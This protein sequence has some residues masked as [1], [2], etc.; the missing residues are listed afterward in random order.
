M[1][2]VAVITGTRADYGILYPVLK[3]I[4]SSQNLKLQ[5]IVC[6]MHL[7]PDFGMTIK[8]IE[9]DGFEISDKFE[10]V[11]SSDTGSSMAKTVGLSIMYAA[12]SFERLK[13]DIVLVLGDRGEMLAAAIAAC[14][15]NIPVAHIHGGEVSGTVDESIRHA[16]TKLSHIHFPA[17][18][19]SRNRIIKMGEK[20]ENVFVVG[21]PGLDVIKSTKYIS[22]EEFLNK[23]GLKDDKIIL[24]TQHPV[25]TE[26]DDVDFQI[27]ETLNAIVSIGKQTVITYPNSD[28]GGRMIIRRIEEYRQKYSFI[29][30]YKNLS[31]YDYLN[32]LNNAD[33]MVGNSSSGIIEAA[34]FKLPVV[35]IGTRQN[36]RLRGINV[37]DAAYSRKE[38]INAINKSLYDDNYIKSLDKCINPYGDG[39]ASGRIVKILNDIKI[40]RNLI[41]KKITY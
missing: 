24:M 9:K 31:Q 8:E 39:N 14:Y 10:T 1:R 28:S 4:D 36:G 13:P 41:Q 15:M 16:I 12:Q 18:E 34:S 23:F 25:T 7:C 33:V 35:N 29:K 11:F 6:G 3:A 19:D 38:I 2:K 17:T 21:A 20:E 26:I 30:V 40:D 22:R 5:L 32:L 37:M 27:R